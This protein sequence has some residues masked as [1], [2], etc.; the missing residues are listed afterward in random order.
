MNDQTKP[1]NTAGRPRRWWQFGLRAL[2][3]FILLVALGLLAARAYLKP[4]W[5]QRQ[6]VAL[7]EKLGGTCQTT[8]DNRWWLRLAGGTQSVTQV[9]LADCDDPEA[10]VAD[11][12]ALP[13]IEL[14]AVG[15]AA[16]TDEHAQRLHRLRTL[17]GL[18]LDCTSVTADGLTALREALK[19]TEV[20]VSQRRAIAA[21]RKLGVVLEDPT[22][23]PPPLSQLAGDEWF[24]EAGLVDIFGPFTDAD[25][26]L[27][28]KLGQRFEL[29]I[30]DGTQ[31]TDAGLE[32][33]SDLSEL[34]S[35]TIENFKLG[36]A[37]IRRLTGLGKLHFVR[38]SGTEI[39]DAGL[40]P[41]K[42]LSQLREL[43]L[44]ETR[45][46]AAGKA[47]LSRALPHCEITLTRKLNPPPAF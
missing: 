19:G 41:F 36:D 32:R 31:L 33:I 24:E 7:V 14:L 47:D 44:L 15:G 2:L 4:Y 26:V 23:A 42:G 18:I 21:M 25:T 3:F 5:Q 6:T 16:F 22:I 35:L 9:K 30:R 45:V 43:E 46:T 10:Y 12:A 17:R 38:L 34:R 40:E 27:L 13:A 28:K 29:S 11:I 1:G 20:Y 37:G 39:T 8:E